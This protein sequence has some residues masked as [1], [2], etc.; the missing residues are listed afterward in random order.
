[1]V[2]LVHVMVRKTLASL[3]ATNVLPQVGHAAIPLARA[4]PADASAS[5]SAA[6]A[7]LAVAAAACAAAFFA[8]FD[9]SLLTLFRFKAGFFNS[10]FSFSLVDGGFFGLFEKR[11]NINMV[12]SQKFKQR[13]RVRLVCKQHSNVIGHKWEKIAI[14]LRSS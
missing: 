6:A 11:R 2:Q 3:T 8:F 5:A 7:A 9:S 1:M 4:S 10:L 14:L 13:I 12:N